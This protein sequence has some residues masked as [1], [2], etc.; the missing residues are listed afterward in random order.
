[1]TPPSA[2][3]TIDVSAGSPLA[4]I[5]HPGSAVRHLRA[6]GVSIVLDCDGPRLPR[7]VHWGADL[8][9]LD[10]ATLQA[11]VRADVQAVVSNVPDRPITPSVLAEHATGWMGLPGLIGH[12]GGADWSTLFVVRSVAT[13]VDLDGTQRVTVQAVDEAARLELGLVLELLRSGVLRMKA[14]VTGSADAD[15]DRPYTLDGLTLSLP[16]PRRAAELLD[17]TGRHLRERHPQRRAFDVGSWVR[18]NRRG[19]TG[20]DA[21]VLLAAGTPG[22]GF[23]HGEVWAVHTAWSGNHRTV[24]ER[25]PNGHALLAG[26]E[27]L[28][29]G[30][31]ALGPGDSY[32]SP[33]IY[34]SYGTG[35]DAVA[36][37]FHRFLRDRPG[38]PAT[39]RPVILNTWESVYFDMDLPT[40]LDLADHAAAVG[41]ERYVL[42]DGW[43]VGR[44]DDHAG[45]GDWQVDPDV[46]PRGL[47]PLVDRVT[48]L[49]MQF[50]LWVEPEMINPDSHVARAHP[51]WIL[52]TG[53][54]LPVE[55]RHQQ[56]LDL[57]N[58]DAFDHILGSLDALL[59][60][61][62]ISYLKWDHNRDLIDAGHRAD[63]RPAV[64][65]QTLAVY[66]LMDELRRRHPRLE[67]ESCSSGGGRIDLE[68]LQRTDRVWASDCIDALERQTIQRY[69]GLLL[70]PELIGAH[71]GTDR[72]HTTGRRH[73][74]SFRAGTALFG[75]MGIEAN[76]ARLSATERAEIADWV[77]LHKRLRPLLHGGR[78]VRFDDVDP[79]L[80]VHGVIADDRSEAVISV[81]AV[82][83]A[84]S[85]PTGRLVLPGLDPDALYDLALL[86]PGD[87]IQD[88]DGHRPQGNNHRL[89]PW[90][91]TGIRLTGAVLGHAGVQWPEL[92]PEQL[93]LLHARR[94]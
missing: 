58:P 22:F 69:T 76:L 29:P 6:A 80:L 42:D 7:V 32:T 73:N 3:P 72:A 36:G 88:E 70:P 4:T 60:E 21:T 84:D 77:A 64:H 12:R 31:V 13:R 16:V 33:W 74:L 62:R 20:S 93:L 48:S 23:G 82:A 46:W 86:P 55:S 27:L 39:P 11:I 50:G 89:P 2:P 35:L 30:E 24:A 91:T 49:G 57:A 26:G 43:F 1:M 51:D 75:H 10:A 47:H 19:R 85:A 66:R 63:G 45:L 52:A 67:I 5:A 68:V 56:V 9:D 17:F 54:R 65:E 40:L 28:L 59:R 79:S 8:G 71:I 37:R 87:M 38:H 15:P 83:T 61:Y 44:R 81:A 92:L 18:D 14:T 41:V 78:V 53:G 94:V 34:G 25:T 90:L